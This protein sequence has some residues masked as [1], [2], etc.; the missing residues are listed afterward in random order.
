M[1]QIL[2]I[3]DNSFIKKN[4]QSYIRQ[5]K[6]EKGLIVKNPYQI[7][8]KFFINKKKNR[9]IDFCVIKFGLSGGIQFNIKNG[10]KILEKNIE[11]YLNVLNCLKNAKIKKVYFV[12]ASCVYPKNLKILNEGDFGKSNIEKTS[13]HYAASKILGT[14]FSLN[15]N[16]NKS[17]KWKSIVPATLYG[18]YNSTDRNNAHVI[19]AFFE[20]FKEP[21]EKLTLWGSG[22]IRREFLH[23]NDFIDA[24]FFINKHKLKKEI[25]N[26]GSC[27]D[28]KI[29]E[30]ANIFSKLTSYKGKIYWDKS[31]P[32]GAKR[33]LLDSSYIMSKGWKPKVELSNGILQLIKNYN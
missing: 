21:R 25:I 16:K 11:G 30:L 33:K 12:S 6:I 13:I 15:V 9:E 18:K 24:I 19:G 28:I 7:S 32:D 14:L 2:L 26:V 4:F 31:K 20:K 5:N 22:N 3:T 10:C 29:K 8:D 1:K 27:T 17:F 23:I